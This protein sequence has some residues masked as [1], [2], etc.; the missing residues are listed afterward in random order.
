[1]DLAGL[2]GIVA[3]QALNRPRAGVRNLLRSR[4]KKQ[5][6]QD[7][8]KQVRHDQDAGRKAQTLSINGGGRCRTMDHLVPLPGAGPR[9]QA[10]GKGKWKKWT[11]EALL[12]V[13]FGGQKRSLRQVAEQVDGGSAAHVKHTQTFVAR[14]VQKGQEEGYARLV[15]Q[16]R[17][18]N[19][20]C[21]LFCILNLMFDETELS[22]A[23]SDHGAGSWS[24]LA[25][26]A[27]VSFCVNGV[28]TDHDIVRA[29]RALCD[30]TAASLFAALSGDLGGLWPGPDAA[31]AR[32]KVTVVTCDANSANLKLLR[33][34]ESCLAD[35]HMMLPVLCAQHRNGNVVE[36]CTKLLG[37]LPGCYSVAKTMASGQSKKKLSD[38]LRDVLAQR[39]VILEAEP[40][41][42]QAEWSQTRADQ[43]KFLEMVTAT[44]LELATTPQVR[45]QTIRDFCNFFSTPWTGPRD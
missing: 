18:G 29:P 37:I 11:P 8:K 22:Y 39:L 45:K 30:K 36:R 5:G 1:M 44:N 9:P 23:V 27:Q 6:K 4:R 38:E 10:R 15:R 13:A 26:H 35:G 32:F 20:V 28:T 42:V 31:G 24:T 7:R 12:R 17:N 40:P 25:S 19:S 34:V 33:H 41:G 2:V 14:L 43:Q 21:P 3:R 16:L